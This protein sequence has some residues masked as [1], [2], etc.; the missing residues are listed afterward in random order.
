M[1]KVPA[2]LV[3]RE[4]N[5]GEAKWSSFGRLVMLICDCSSSLSGFLESD[6]AVLPSP[7]PLLVGAWRQ[8]LRVSNVSSLS[9]GSAT[10]S[11]DLFAFFFFLIKS[12]RDI[13]EPRNNQS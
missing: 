8:R 13:S 4:V 10:L 9:W 11:L 12:I 7:A 3:T 2:I 5:S 1:A 6:L